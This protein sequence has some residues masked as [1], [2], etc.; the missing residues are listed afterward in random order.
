[1]GITE[2]NLKKEANLEEVGIPGYNLV[3]DMG[4]ENKIK[5]NSRVVAYVK[6]ELSYEVVKKYMGGD[7]MPEVWLKL[8][9]AGTKRSLVG[10][11]YREHKPWKSRDDS[12]RGQEERLKAWLEARRS[13]WG[14]AEEAFLLGD[15]NLDWKRQGDTSYRNSKMLKNLERE[16]T[17]LGWTQLVQ[18]NTH[19]SN[20]NGVISET[21]IDHVWTNCP[22]KVRRCRQEETAA[23]DHQLVWVERSA[24][25]LV[26]KVKKTEKRMMKNFKLEDLEELCKIE[27]WS[28][29]GSQERTPN[30]LQQRVNNLENKIRNIL[31]K[32]APMKTKNLVYRGKPRWISTDIDARLKE[33]HRARIRANKT[34]SMVDE[35]EARSIRNIAAKEIKTAR[36]DYLK[37]KMENLSKNSP[38][39]W[40]AV[41]EYLGWKKPMTPT[42]LVQ[43]G[44]VLT[45]GPELAEAMLKQYK[46]KEDEVQKSL[47]EASGDYLAAGRKLT[48]GNKAVFAFRKVTREQVEKQIQMVDNEESFGHDGI[49]YGFLKKMSKWI[50][51]ELTQIMNLSL[52]TKCYPDSW[53]VA[54]VKPL[55]KGEGNDRQAPKAYRP[56][57]LLSGM[58][59][60][61]EAL[62][63]KQL[64]QYQ[65]DNGL[66]H[67]GVHGF[68][69]GRGT[70]TAMLEVWEFVLRRTEQ[71]ELVALDFLDCSAGFDTLV[72]LYILRKMQT[73]FGMAQDSLEWLS[74]YLQGWTQYG[75]VEASRSKDRKMKKGAPQ[76]GGLSPIIWRSATN[77]IP[78]A[79]LVSERE[80]QAGTVNLRDGQLPERERSEDFVSK[81]IDIKEEAQLSTEERLDKRMRDENVWELSKW[82]EE[83][84]GLGQGE[85]DTLAQ[86]ITED[87]R[88]VITTICADDT[89]SRAAAKTK[90][91]L[92]KRNSEGLTKVCKELK[93]LRL[94]VNEGK[95]TYMVLATQ[96][97]RRRET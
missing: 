24:K 33:R 40:S 10:F 63:A 37:K 15:I 62:L 68:R 80:P 29:K 16:L 58:S 12:V 42:K 49:S 26:D 27:E 7:L 76:G 17:E 75:V 81:I 61:M 84:I 82:R 57:A 21:L 55:F 47:G 86:K 72:H 11:V 6:E 95:T 44:A 51:E 89:Q 66:V 18:Q 45:K 79:G 43:D 9:H 97:R 2:A 94:K 83:R 69:K 19:F 54:R 46:R 20:R 32:V 48:S 88:D 31:E 90:E 70:N 36:K 65:E 92:E 56:V 71:G 78:E 28:H 91:D 38:D 25:N 4:I 59:R 73:Q 1:M 13:V 93:S 74:S 50:G 14:G 22:V 41:N 23:S 8:G 35:L 87:E 60:I 96:G 85:E 30:M 34:K 5:K 67:Q 3:C 64:D 77:D 52:E 53:K 39:A